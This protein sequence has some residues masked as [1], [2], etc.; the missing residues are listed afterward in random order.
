M[1]KPIDHSAA[2][3]QSR[4]ALISL[5]LSLALSSLSTSITN[6]ALPTLAD[7]FSAS[8]QHVQWIVLANLLAVTTLIVGVG[9]LGDMF[10]RRRL[11]LMGLIVFTVA[12]VLCA[13]APNL[14]L[15]IAA[16]AV[17]GVGAAIL[18]AL[19]TALVGEVVPK[20]KTGS[21][22]GMLG[23]ASAVGTA[24]GP[25]LGGFLIAWFDWRAIFIV[26]VVTGIIT[27]GLVRRFVM[28]DRGLSPA[29]GGGFDYTGTVVLGVVLAAYAL[30]MTLG[31]GSFGA[32]NV[33]LLIFAVV[34]IGVFVRVEAKAISPLIR[35]SVLRNQTLSAGVIMSALVVTV[36]MATMVVGPFYLTGALKL[37]AVTVGLVLSAG[38]IVAA[39][40][41][42]P[43][44]RLVDRFGARAVMMAGLVAIALGA[45]MLALMSIGFGVLGVCCR[46]RCFDGGVCVV[47]SRQQYG[48][49]GRCCR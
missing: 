20:E 30:A 24:L 43:S 6:M 3:K 31:R 35:L 49:H 25:S 48:R 22:M 5:S 26:M 42:V 46:H 10:G 11:L 18:M 1:T 38:P 32:M 37:N 23:T 45:L 12:S 44:G 34:G 14:G 40:S 13:V 47:S 15:L 16:R 39:L 27:Y 9:R 7:L 36:A 29:T 4:W 28:A 21:A 41:G 17:Q 2:S 33:C 8:F 19:S